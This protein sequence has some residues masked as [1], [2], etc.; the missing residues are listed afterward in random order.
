MRHKPENLYLVGIIPGPREPPGEE[1]DHFLR[2]LV[3]VMKES[4]AHGKPYKTHDYPYGRLV[5]SAI[6][7]SVNEVAREADLNL[8]EPHTLQSVQEDAHK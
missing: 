6:A 7:L 5:R 1:I 8:L 3:K 2:P 4:W